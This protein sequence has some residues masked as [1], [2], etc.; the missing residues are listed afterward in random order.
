MKSEANKR[1][2]EWAK[3]FWR[4][5]REDPARFA[6]MQRKR[7]QGFKE[8]WLSRRE[9]GFFS[10]KRSTSKGQSAN[11]VHDT[12]NK[13]ALRHPRGKERHS[14]EQSKGEKA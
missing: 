14:G 9:C 4:K 1:R 7:A 8:R 11:V 12:P 10:S 2:S 6:R 3:E 13:R 5:L